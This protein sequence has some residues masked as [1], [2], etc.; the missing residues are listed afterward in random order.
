MQY[1]GEMAAQ[2]KEA[3]ASGQVLRY[4]GK[5]DVAAGTASVT[6]SRCGASAAAIDQKLI[7]S[8]LQS[9]KLA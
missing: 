2:A 5:V 6:T 3:A 8:I 7:Y 1:D 9:L 4:V